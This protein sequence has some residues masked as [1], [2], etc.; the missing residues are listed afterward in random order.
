[1][2][3]HGGTVTASSDGLGYGSEF[4]VQLPMIDSPQLTTAE[5]IERDQPDRSPLPALRILVVDDVQASAKTL[6]LMLQSLGQNTEVAFDGPSA[7]ARIKERTFDVVFLD[8]AMPGM[9]GLAV[10]RHLRTMSGLT[11]LTLI[12]LTGFG[13]E[14]DRSHSLEAGFNY[15]LTKPVSLDLLKDIL[16]RTSRQQ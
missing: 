2:E 7:I 1:V 4:V 8:I 6:A 13:Q 3:L 9:D 11:S 10:A 14:E 5:T 15:H 12:A 16:A